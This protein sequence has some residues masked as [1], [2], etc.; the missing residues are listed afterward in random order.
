[1]REKEAQGDLQTV[2]GAMRQSFT[3]L[4]IAINSTTVLVTG[5]LKKYEHQEANRKQS[6]HSIQL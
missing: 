4:S 1:M 5:R 6:A 2:M 3:P